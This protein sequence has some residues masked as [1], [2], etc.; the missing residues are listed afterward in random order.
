MA[1]GKLI[2]FEG[3]DGVGKATQVALLAKR[4]RAEKKHVTVFSIPR[5]KTPVG[6]LIKSALQGEYG[7]FR[8]LDPHLSA[9]PYLLDY[10]LARESFLASLKKGTVIFDRYV[11]STFAYHSAKVEGAA[12][13][14]LL[15]ELEYLAFNEIRLPKPDMIIYLDVPPDVSRKLMDKKKRDQHERDSAYQQRV[16]DM[17]KKMAKGKSWHVIA[18]APSGAMRSRNDIHEEIWRLVGGKNARR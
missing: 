17:Y 10:M 13:Q 9:L 2:V 18:C 16:A 4:L 8:H 3:I 5:Y 15:R 12:Q 1:R 14:K 7:D 11:E 6:R